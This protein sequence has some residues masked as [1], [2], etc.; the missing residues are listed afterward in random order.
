[1]RQLVCEFDVQTKVI[2]QKPIGLSY[3]AIA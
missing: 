3:V 2:S 1:V